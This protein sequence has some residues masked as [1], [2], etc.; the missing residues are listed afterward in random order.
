MLCDSKLRPFPTPRIPG[1]V[2]T[3]VYRR[4]L[5]REH[6]VT[7][8]NITVFEDIAMSYECLCYAD[9]V[10]I[11]E[12]CPYFY[13][14]RE[15]SIL[16]GYRPQNY[17]AC[18]YCFDYIRGRIGGTRDFDRQINAFF[19]AE[20]IWTIYAEFRVGRT[21]S[22]VLSHARTELR[23]TDIA[24]DLFFDGLT[25]KYWLYLSLLKLHAYFPLVL[26]ARILFR[27]A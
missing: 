3:K 2:P 26:T 25:F 11:C 23:A 4:S 9:T 7:D 17:R 14:F 19:T 22:Q 12:E 5:V 18:R 21:F 6:Y 27:G 13:R 20:T 16:Q 8:T 1:Y 15:G 10:Y 24:A